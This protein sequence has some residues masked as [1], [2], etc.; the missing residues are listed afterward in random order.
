[1]WGG[2]DRRSDRWVG[3]RLHGISWALVRTRALVEA[4]SSQRS[5]EVHLCCTWITLAACGMRTGE[6]LG[7]VCPQVGWSAGVANS[8][9]GSPSAEME[10]ISTSRGSQVRER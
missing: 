7:D 4:R 5:D 10:L 9:M 1:M 6:Q 3:A 8:N 2:R